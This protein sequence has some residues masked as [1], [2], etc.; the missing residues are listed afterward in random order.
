[1]IHVFDTDVAEKY[2]VNAAIILQNIGFWIKQNEANRVN[3]YDGN[4]WTFNS[5]RAYRELFPYLS[6][7][8]IRTAFEKL[9]A[10]GVLITGNYNQ[11]GYDRTLWYALTEKGKTICRMEQ[12][13]LPLGAN[14]K[15]PTGE[16]IPNINAGVTPNGKPFIYP[17]DE[18]W[19]AYPKKKAKEDARKAWAKLKPDEALGKAIIQAVEESKKA[20]DWKKEK[21]KYIPYPATYLNGKRWEDERNDTDGAAAGSTGNPPAVRYGK[22]V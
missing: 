2:G 7:K 6:A 18:F 12:N 17:F 11:K 22:C 20:D 21:G 8:Q 1:M 13:H 10:D 14:G 3:F 5:Q 15:A 16:P 9:I 4:Y 19:A